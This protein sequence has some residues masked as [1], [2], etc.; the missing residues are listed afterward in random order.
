MHNHFDQHLN[1]RQHL[2]R[3]KPSHVLEIGAGTGEC[4]RKIAG[5]MEDLKFQFSIINDSV[6]EGLDASINQIQGVSY[7][8]IEKLPDN[9]VDFC[10][11]ATDHNY[12]TL[13]S[14]LS[15]LHPKLMEDGLI[16]LHDV[17]TFYHATGMAMRYGNGTP[18][19]ADMIELHG[20]RYGGLGD[21][22]ID[23]LSANRRCYKMI[24][25][26]QESQGGCI[27][28]KHLETHLDFMLAGPGSDYS[29][30]TQAEVDEW[31]AKHPM[32][33]WEAKEAA[34]AR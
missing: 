2:L 27:M 1:I 3:S 6:I 24:A 29:Q 4:T 22:V 33:I 14:E 8:E 34:H 17:W 10:I 32:V 31:M 7:R 28:Q 16:L 15:A 21:A 11:I 30:Q 19:P 12:W 25:F 20:V 23:F 18:Y 13:R 26:T 9:S 5:L